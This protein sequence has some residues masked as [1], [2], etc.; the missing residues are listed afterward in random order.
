MSLAYEEEDPSTWIDVMNLAANVNQ[1]VDV[2]QDAE[3]AIPT[4]IQSYTDINTNYPAGADTQ[5]K[6]LQSITADADICKC[7]DCKC[8]PSNSCC[9]TDEQSK[10][11]SQ[12]PCSTLGAILK[13][14][15]DA[16]C[17][18]TL[19]EDKKREECCVVVCLKSLEQLR[20][21]LALANGCN[22]FQTLTLGCV[23]SDLCAVN[24]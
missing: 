7:S 3:Q 24:K 5:P 9:G 2:Y 17:K 6:T 10:E 13:T 22:A 15:A 12:K 8:G 23:S 11:C 21:I 16:D 14:C 20:Q 4:G 1:P 19:Q 18:I